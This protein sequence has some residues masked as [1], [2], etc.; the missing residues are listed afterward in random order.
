MS[1]MK[2]GCGY[3]RNTECDNFVKSTFLINHGDVFYCPQCRQLGQVEQEKGFYRGEADNFK[4]VR[5]EFSYEPLTNTYRQTAI[6]RDDAIIGPA[7]VYTLQSPLIQQ[8]R[9]ALKVAEAILAN[10]NRFN[11][12]NRDEIPSTAEMILNLDL[13]RETFSKRLEELGQELAKIQAEQQGAKS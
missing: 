8:E 4:E 2:R 6:V 12:L 7:N 9:R 5:V 10:L 13:D 3:C 11:G 1:R